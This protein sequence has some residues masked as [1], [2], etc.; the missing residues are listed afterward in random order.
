M[1]SETSTETFTISNYLYKYKNNCISVRVW[2]SVDEHSGL[3]YKN[4]LRLAKWK[5]LFLSLQWVCTKSGFWD[6]I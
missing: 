2:I 5:G 3:L 4:H 1:F 6:N